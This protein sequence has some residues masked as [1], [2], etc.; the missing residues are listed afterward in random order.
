MTTFWLVLLGVGIAAWLW[1]LARADYPADPLGTWTPDMA[2]AFRAELANDGE[3]LE[4]RLVQHHL[5]QAAAALG[6]AR[7]VLDQL[8]DS[9]E[10]YVGAL[11]ELEE[12]RAC[13]RAVHRHADAMTGE[14]A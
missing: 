14:R 3:D 12:A 13:I 5:D 2:D 11:T 7:A 4:A 6:R 8:A 1:V 10:S 9:D